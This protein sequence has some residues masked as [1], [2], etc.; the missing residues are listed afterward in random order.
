MVRVVRLQLVALG[1]LL[2]VPS[3][4]RAEAPAPEHNEQAEGL[5]AEGRKLED[6]GDPGKA[7]PL[8]EQAVELA[9]AA[10]G[11]RLH[12]ARCLERIGKLASA[13][14]AYEMAAEIAK[15]SGQFSRVVH[16][17]GRLKELGDRLA[18]VTLVVPPAT[19]AAM[20][21]LAVELDG[22]V[23]ARGRW[24]TKLA[25]DAGTHEVVALAPGKVAWRREVSLALGDAFT[26]E[27]GAPGDASAPRWAWVVGGVGV[28]LA[29]GAVASGVELSAAQ[30]D[31]HEH[32]SATACDRAGGFEPAAANARLDRDL[33]LVLGLGIS[34]AAAIAAAGVGLAAMDGGKARDEDR[35][36]SASLDA[37]GAASGRVARRRLDA[38]GAATRRVAMSRVDAE[39]AASGSV[40]RR[41]VAARRVAVAPYLALTPAQ[42]VTGAGWSLSIAL[43]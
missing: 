4:A 33:G 17:K 37:E 24:G 35:A 20:P 26:I 12:L 27:V 28:A 5:F 8:Y 6:A 21:A 22:A 1:L 41:R 13:H 16:A 7:C 14:A 9:P 42:G 40:A 2:A 30:S 18:F 34:G 43:E 32:C 36:E 15:K 23:V 10:V 19:Q 39:G 38:E 3:V 25:A 31:I 29:A 11:G